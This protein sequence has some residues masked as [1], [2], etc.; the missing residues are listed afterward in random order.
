MGKKEFTVCDVCGKVKE[1]AE[2]T[3]EIRVTK[4]GGVTLERVD[5]CTGCAS[6][7]VALMT[8]RGAQKKAPKGK[9]RK[10]KE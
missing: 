3:H 6:A 10:P 4:K 7:V 2:L 9:P 1:S 8:R 5:V